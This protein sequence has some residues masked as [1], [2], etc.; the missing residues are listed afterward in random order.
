MKI[1]RAVVEGFRGSNPALVLELDEKSTCFLGENGS[2]KT[3]IVDALELWST[4]D[5]GAFHRHQCGLDAAVH[6]DAAEAKVT[7]E[8]GNFGKLS[9]TLRGTTVSVLTPEGPSSVTGTLPPIPILR[10]RTMADFMDMKIGEK[11]KALLELLGLSELEPFRAAVI[12]ASNSAA[13]ESSDAQRRFDEE[14]VV[15]RSFTGEATVVETADSLRVAAGLPDAITTEAHLIAATFTQSPSVA[16]GAARISAVSEAA[17]ALGAAGDTPPAWNAT[18]GDKHVV[19]ADAA[20]ALLEAGERV[21]SR[22]VS[23]ECPLCLQSVDRSA[24][25]S[26]IS[27][28]LTALR[29]NQVS[30]EAARQ[31]L[32]AHEATLGRLLRALRALE[33]CAPPGGWS[34][35]D[36][37]S[38]VGQIEAALR[39]IQEA[40]ANTTEAPR[41]PDR[42]RLAAKVADWQAEAAATSGEASAEALAKLVSLR[43]AFTR[44]DVVGARLKC[45]ERA[46]GRLEKFNQLT[47]R[48]VQEA[49]EGGVRQIGALAA[50]YYSRLVPGGIYSD[51]KIVAVDAYAGGFEF[52]LTYAGKTVRPPQRVL[53]E[54][55]LN[56]LGLVFFLARLKIDPQPWRTVVLDDVVNSFDSD[57][58]AGLARLLDEEFAEWQVLLLTHDR[59]FADVVQGVAGGGWRYREIVQWTPAGGLVFADGDASAQLR[60]RLDSGEAASQLGGLARVALERALARPV[61]KLGLD[62]RYDARG[63]YSAYDYLRALRNAQKVPALNDLAKVLNRVEA[64]SYITNL[65]AHDR[66][67]D[68]GATAADLRALSADIDDFDTQLKCTTC[69]KYVWSVQ[70]KGH[71]SCGC[72]ANLAV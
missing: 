70:S 60:S 51:V 28:R 11:R 34:E 17:G 57:H 7:C 50:D 63:R 13:K 54:S 23:D 25:L 2:G 16:S 56:A 49:I 35:W 53:S 41:G 12:T 55:Q 68:V 71:F 65:V 18:I 61:R 59:V 22:Y 26:D 48:G 37:V 33:A 64:S 14:D 8:G 21:V 27:T 15:V 32:A 38:Q 3:T 58:R 5:I 6:L 72:A 36:E 24:L 69:K 46:A 29:E 19:E 39:G 62:I 20:R 1:R 43:D 52:E 10:H 42:S 45:A 4:G 44:R 30:L 66:P 31:E 47:R 40:L 9:R 67:A